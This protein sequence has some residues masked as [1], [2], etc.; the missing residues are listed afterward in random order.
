MAEPSFYVALLIALGAA[1]QWL[2]WRVNL[3]AILPLLI[4]GFIVGPLTGLVHPLEFISEDL[5]FPAVGLAVGLILFEGGLTLKLPEVREVRRV[6]LNLISIGALITWLS[7][8]L[9]SYLLIGLSWPIALLFGALV[10]VTGPTVIGPLMRSVRAAPRVANI[11]KWEGILIDPLGALVAVLVFEF[12]LLGNSDTAV[13]HTLSSLVLFVVVGALVGGVGGLAF[14]FLLRRRFVPDYLTNLVALALVFSV[15]A[16]SNLLSPES[17]LLAT[18]VMGML[19][20]NLRAPNIGEILTFKEDLSLL[21]I[22]LLFI[23]LAANIDLGAFVAALTWQSLALVGVIMF[24][25]RPLNI[26]VSTIGSPL[27]WREKLFLSWI[28]PRGIVAASVTSLFASRLTRADV[29]GAEVLVPLVFIIIVGSVT[30][31]SLTA[32]PVARLLGVAEPEPQGVLLLGAHTVA[33]QIADFLQTEGFATVVADTNYANITSARLAGL[34]AYYGSPLSGRA[35]EELRLSG[36]GNLLALTSNDE[37]NALAAM[38][39]ARSFDSTHVFQLKP[40]ESD[41]NTLD[42]ARRGRLIFGDGTTFDELIELFRSGEIKKTTLT[43][44]FTRKDFEVRNEGY[45]P[46]FIVRNSVRGKTLIV[47]SGASLDL[48]T[49]DTLVSLVPDKVGAAKNE[50]EELETE[51]EAV[52]LEV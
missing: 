34:N 32:K 25:V 6:V 52:A 50:S 21:F 12:L 5:L 18:T 24:V 36:I 27:S 45:M 11:L 13:G 37:A 46:L 8:T 30:L 28:A 26:F 17:G 42:E 1:A 9:A 51:L 7:V 4:I 3:P 23:V 29:G 16:L 40:G 15:Y 14:T 33:R 49:G 20:A 19:M 39:F 10:I 35:D 31:N 43:E 44:A 41:R 48:A 47:I 22:S 2:A 38:K